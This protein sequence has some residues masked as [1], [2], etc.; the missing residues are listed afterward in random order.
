MT[1][2]KLW[3]TKST[4]WKHSTRLSD[5]LEILNEKSLDLSA[6]ETIFINCGVN[7]I[8]YMRGS[9]VH[10]LLMSTIDTITQRLPHVKIVVSE[11]T[12]RT[13]QKDADVIK[14]NKMLADS[15][16]MMENVI[17]IDHSNLRGG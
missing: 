9:E 17:L 11:I 6:L 10:K 2:G 14:C 12:P 5:I 7:D 16:L 15:I 13:D 3:S 4:T 1:P 8:D